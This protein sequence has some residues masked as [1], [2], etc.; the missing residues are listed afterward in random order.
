[1]DPCERNRRVYRGPPHDDELASKSKSRSTCVLRER[2][3]AFVKRPSSG[4]S[5]RSCEV[6]VFWWI[7]VYRPIP[8]DHRL[9]GSPPIEIGSDWLHQ[10]GDER[11]NPIGIDPIDG[12]GFVLHAT[13]ERRTGDVDQ[14]GDTRGT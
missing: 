10:L 9:V 11:V 5:A 4:P 2:L 1:A 6:A 8:A 14:L 13:V 12:T 7:A 3:S